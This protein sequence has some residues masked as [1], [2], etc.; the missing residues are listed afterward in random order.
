MRELG[1]ESCVIYVSRIWCTRR[2]KSRPCSGVLGVRDL[3]Q[4][5]AALYRP[6][7]RYY[8]DLIDEAAALWESRV[9]NHSFIDGNK[10]T[11][12]SVTYTFLVIDGDEERSTQTKLTILSPV[13]MK[14]TAL[15]LIL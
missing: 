12:F 14:Q 9:Q 15:A 11:S 2:W 13:C 7:M 1:C 5:E 10:S 4:L 3:G 8:V 6:Q